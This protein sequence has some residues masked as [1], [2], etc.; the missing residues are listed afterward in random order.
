MDAQQQPNSR[1]QLGLALSLR[2][3]YA[4]S[5]LARPIDALVPCRDDGFLSCHQHTGAFGGALPG[6]GAAEGEVGVLSV[7]SSTPSLQD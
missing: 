4:Y 7:R 5:W 1:P 3:C 2:P 6:E